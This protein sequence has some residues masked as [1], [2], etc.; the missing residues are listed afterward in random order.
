MERNPNRRQHKADLV[1]SR[2]ERE[3]LLLE[4]GFTFHEIVESV[5]TIVRI[6]HQRRRTVNNVRYERVWEE[7]VVKPAILIKKKFQ[8][9]SSH[10]ALHDLTDNHDRMMEAPVEFKTV[11]DSSNGGGD[12]S[13]IAPLQS[14][15]KAEA[16]EEEPFFVID[17]DPDV[18]I[19]DQEEISSAG[20]GTIGSDG[21]FDLL[22]RDTSYW[23]LERNNA[24][25]PKISR[26][27]LAIVVSEEPIEDYALSRDVPFG[28]PPYLPQNNGPLLLR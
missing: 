22:V 12:A 3:S 26:K 19:Y 7:V 21:N 27:A 11:I 5:R 2:Q 15:Q 24:M 23:E 16:E 6:K 20:T 10:N 14:M 1:L 18:Y 17:N 28:I 4:W 25:Y 13:P 8:K 9:S